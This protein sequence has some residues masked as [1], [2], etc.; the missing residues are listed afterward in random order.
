MT[1][2][3]HVSTTGTS[4]A[5]SDQTAPVFRPC[6]PIIP[7]DH[8]RSPAPNS[9]RRALPPI[10][11]LRPCAVCQAEG[12]QMEHSVRVRVRGARREPP[13]AARHRPGLRVPGRQPPQA[14][15]QRRCQA[16]T[17]RL[18]ID[19]GGKPVF[20]GLDAAAAGFEDAWAGAGRPRRARP[21]LPLLGISDGAAGLIAAETTMPARSVGPV[22]RDV[23]RD[24]LGLEGTRSSRVAWSTD[25]GE[26]IRGSTHSR[27]HR[28]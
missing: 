27:P 11:A 26:R 17:G 9:F 6:H 4:P 20:V 23:N 7:G 18:R 12:V 8:K 3:W 25:H 22:M 13:A 28:Q 24:L 14:P 10:C 5:M 16:G 21:G 15:R 1:R 19:T 2:S